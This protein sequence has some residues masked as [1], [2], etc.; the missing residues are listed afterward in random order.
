VH[1][2]LYNCQFKTNKRAWKE[3]DTKQE[4]ELELVVSNIKWGV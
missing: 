3:G 1:D 4:V 2:K